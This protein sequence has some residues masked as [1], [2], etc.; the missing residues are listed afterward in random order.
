MRVQPLT[1]IPANFGLFEAEI[2]AGL[3][4]L[5]GEEAGRQYSANARSRFQAT[6]AH[7][8][9]RAWAAR[10]GTEVAG[11]LFTVER[12]NA[13]QV[14]FIHVL[15]P[16][17]GRHVE[18]GL[19]RAAL[20]HAW[21][22]DVSH[23]LCEVVAFCPLDLGPAMTPLGFDHISREL[24]IA[25]MDALLQQAGQSP[26]DTREPTPYSP[27]HWDAIAQCLLDAYAGEPGSRLHIEVTDSRRALGFVERVALGSFGNV[28]SQYQ[29]ALWQKDRCEGAVLGCEVA[30]NTG[31]VLQVVTAPEA[32][33]KGIATR[34][35]R[36][37]AA[38][39][40][41]QGLTQVALGVTRSNPAR[42]LYEQLGFR[43]AQPVDAYI[44]WRP[45][46][47]PLRR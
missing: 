47:D 29:L 2:A 1:T 38:S 15:K 13:A 10:E 24:M 43:H 35:L 11:Y 9:V 4:R 41:E 34:L 22:K 44:W 23:I 6:I 17:V 21:D 30:P 25:P 28:L 45:G 31:F 42:R 36:A 37:L 18:A 16:Y 19:V 39:F 14:P 32:R 40:A 3:V 12:D 33:G 46:H 26:A 5:Y 7:P 27:R 20:E 8:S